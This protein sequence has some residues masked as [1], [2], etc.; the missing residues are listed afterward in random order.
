MAEKYQDPEEGVTMDK[1]YSKG[2][3]KIPAA[4]LYRHPNGTEAIVT[5]DP[6]WGNAQAQA[7]HRL[8]F[9]FVREAKPEEVKTLPELAA[10]SRKAEEGNLKG[11]AARLDKL[12]GV[13]SENETLQAEVKKLQD[14]LAKANS[15]ESAVTEKATKTQKA[16]PK[17]ATETLS[18]KE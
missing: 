7:F 17:V 15:Q 3:S 16:D 1:E 6:L 14:E 5:G 10:D 11:L 18:K 9:K 2:G 4:G 8:G 12:E 13:A